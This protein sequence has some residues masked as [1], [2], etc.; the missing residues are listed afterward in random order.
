MNRPPACPRLSDEMGNKESYCSGLMYMYN[1]QY[2]YIDILITHFCSLVNEKDELS[3]LEGERVLIVLDAVS[4]QCPD[5]LGN[6]LKNGIIST[7]A[8]N[9][10]VQRA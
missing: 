2:M 8:M 6:N 10:G 4:L 5:L 3:I 1:V 7:N 9:P